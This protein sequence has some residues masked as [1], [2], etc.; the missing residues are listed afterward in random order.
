[1]GANM[2]RSPSPQHHETHGEEQA[3]APTAPQAGT[4]VEPTQDDVLLGRGS[5]MMRWSGNKRYQ[6]E[7]DRN[8]KRYYDSSGR[9]LRS[10]IVL[11]V[12][13]T[14]EEWGG[15]FLDQSEP[16]GPWCIAEFTKVRKKVGHVRETTP[17][18]E[19]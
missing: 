9:S 4:V 6:V 2:K 7:V 16:N 15:R 13:R 19:Y 18:F 12:M 10:K 1:M 5:L 8:A 11:E 3:A 14:V 17:L